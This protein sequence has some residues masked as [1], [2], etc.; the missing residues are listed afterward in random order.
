MPK[1]FVC[2]VVVVRLPRKW[3]VLE[4]RSGSFT[5]RTPP[6]YLGTMMAS[7]AVRH[8]ILEFSARV[9]APHR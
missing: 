9:L 8:D 6:P 7:R 2:I 4:P 3:T 1:S 5:T